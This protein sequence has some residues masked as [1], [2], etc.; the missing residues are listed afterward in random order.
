MY[1]Q[2]YMPV[3][4]QSSWVLASVIWHKECIKQLFGGSR[5]DE[6]NGWIS[7]L[8]TILQ[9]LLRPLTLFF[10]QNRGIWPLTISPS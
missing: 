7:W 5:K 4:T 8:M 9:V 3:E 1:Q 6:T 10:R 2:Q